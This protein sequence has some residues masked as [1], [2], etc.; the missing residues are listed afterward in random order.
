MEMCVH[1]PRMLILNKLQ[2]TQGHYQVES[3]SSKIGSDTE[4][5]KTWPVA[6]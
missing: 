2:V 1:T 3:F 5:G 4:T 6:K